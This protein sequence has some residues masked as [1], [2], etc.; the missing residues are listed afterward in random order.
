MWAVQ[1][2]LRTVVKLLEYI[3]R[4]VL[5]GY[6]SPGIS[7]GSPVST[8]TLPF[9][10]LGSKHPLGLSSGTVILWVPQSGSLPALSS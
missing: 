5:W 6:S 2:A 1:I 8:M 9:H 3:L 7:A 4:S 10:W